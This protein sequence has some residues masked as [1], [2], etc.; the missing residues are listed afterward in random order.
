ADAQALADWAVLF[1]RHNE[2]ACLMLRTMSPKFYQQRDNP[3]LGT[4]STPQVM[5]IQGGRAQ[6]YK[7]QGKAKGKGKEEGH[8]KRNCHV[9]LA[10]L[11]K[12]KKKSGGQM[13]HP[14]LQ[15]HRGE[16]KLKRGSLYL[17][18]GNGVRAEV[19]AMEVWT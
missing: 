10:E 16:K 7:P 1:Y 15:G 6:K 13:L 2:V 17:Y 4:S 11:M 5:A 14:L 3:L 19:E 9:Y 18:V 8:W 12:K